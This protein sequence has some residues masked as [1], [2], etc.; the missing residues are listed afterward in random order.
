QLAVTK[1]R[2][3]LARE[4]LVEKRRFGEKADSLEDEMRQYE[5]L[6]QQ[7]QDDI[8]QLEEKL[9]SVR[10]K[11][12]VLVQRHI[13][14]QKKRRA[15]EEIRNSISTDAFIRFEQF[16]SR[17]ER[18][19]AEADLVNAFRKPDLEEQFSRLEG[20]EEIE[21]ELEALKARLKRTQEGSSDN[22]QE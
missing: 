12:R 5:E 3:D 21:E 4:A 7:Y 22:T 15:Q 1:G 11:Q 6:V 20:D 19:E 18:M 10:E 14:A 8:R 16:E 9:H 13:H 17:I 2:E